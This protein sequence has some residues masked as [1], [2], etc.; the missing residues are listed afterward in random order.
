MGTLGKS[1][2]NKTGL[3]FDGTPKSYPA[4]K[5]AVIAKSDA[6]GY[7]WAINGGNV[8][9][10]IFQAANAKAAK[11]KAA[12]TPKKTSASNTIS[13]NIETYD[14]GEVKSEFEKASVTVSLAL[15]VRKHR[16]ELLGTHYADHEKQGVTPDQLNEMHK[17]MDVTYLTKVNRDLTRALHDAVFSNT[18]AAADTIAV[19]KLRTILKTQEVAKILS[20]ENVGS[21]KKWAQEP[22]LMPAIQMW[23]KLA[24]RFEG[25]TDMINGHFMDD[26]AELLNS[27]TGQRRKT[28]YEIDA[29]FEKMC[30]SLTDNFSTLKSLMPFLRASLRQTMIRKLSKVGKDKEAWKKAENFLTELQDDDHML[31]VEDT[32]DAIKRAQQF[33]HRNE[34]DGAGSKDDTKVA[35]VADVDTSKA[36]DDKIAEMGAKIEALQA[37]LKKQQAP[38]TGKRH[39]NGK[40]VGEVSVCESCGKRGHT[41]DQCW[42]GLDE[43]KAKIEKAIAERDKKKSEMAKRQ[44]S[45]KDTKAYVAAC[46]KATAAAATTA[47]GA[48]V[49]CCRVTSRFTPRTSVFHAHRHA[50][51]T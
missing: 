42:K 29:E 5:E 24:Y 44:P 1:D 47:A 33:L 3:R 36:Q 12:A 6:E 18:S 28:F 50:S 38:G 32:D 22:W 51:C 14:D 16:K 19:T 11:K 4:F 39:R 46:N 13:L 23:G 43:A 49:L 10:A 26:L 45:S 34:D 8:I 17:H 7:A 20:G 35:F 37:Q 30:K 9:C 25:M 27:A 21:E 41:K 48:R 2:N 40:P 31:T 15:Q